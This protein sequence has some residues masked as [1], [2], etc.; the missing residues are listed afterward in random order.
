MTYNITGGEVRTLSAI[1]NQAGGTI[2]LTPCVQDEIKLSDKLTAY[3]GGRYDSVTHRDTLKCGGVDTNDLC[4]HDQNLSPKV[5]MVYRPQEQTT[6]EHRSV[7]IPRPQLRT[8]WWTPMTGFTYT[9]SL[10]KPETVTSW[11]IGVEQQVGTTYASR[12]YYEYLKDL[13]YRTQMISC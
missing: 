13:I 3:L 10:L 8:F 9:Q 7:R 5:S 1:A 12:H 2:R 4:S 6:R 11:E